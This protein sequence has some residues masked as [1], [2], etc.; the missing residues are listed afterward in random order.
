MAFS[1]LCSLFSLDFPLSFPPS[2]P[3]SISFCLSLPPSFHHSLPFFLLFSPSL[4]LS[5]PYLSHSHPPSLLLLSLT[6]CLLLIITFLVYLF[7]YFSMKSLLHIT[8]I[9]IITLLLLSRLTM[10]RAVFDKQDTW[11]SLL[12]TFHIIQSCIS[13]VYTAVHTDVVQLSCE[14]TNKYADMFHRRFFSM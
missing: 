7:R 13:F 8:Y 10:A 1:L 3:P 11:P 12:T 4:P 9:I 14:N 6:F 2:L 5:S